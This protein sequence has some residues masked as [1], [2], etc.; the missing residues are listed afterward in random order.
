MAFLVHAC[1]F[2]S[3]SRSS[4]FSLSEEAETEQGKGETL[5]LCLLLKCSSHI[6]LLAGGGRNLYLEGFSQHASGSGCWRSQ[7]D[8]WFTGGP[9][10]TRAHNLPFLDWLTMGPGNCSRDSRLASGQGR[11][12]YPKLSYFPVPLL[13]P[14]VVAGYPQ[15]MHPSP[16][17][18]LSV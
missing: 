12:T 15:P 1:S 13:L 18:S 14:A 4:A 11:I 5:L 9:P 17:A 7:V 8:V 6:F 3:G 16:S 10:Y 2:G